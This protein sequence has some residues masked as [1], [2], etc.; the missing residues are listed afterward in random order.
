[1]FPDYDEEEIFNKGD[2][3]KVSKEYN[4]WIFGGIEGKITGK[5]DVSYLYLKSNKKTPETT[6]Q[7][8]NDDGFVQY[9]PVR[10]LEKINNSAGG[11]RRKSK[12]SKRKSRCGG[13]KGSRKN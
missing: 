11:R 6:Y 2:R 7:V 5:K 4:D 13:R 12:T 10:F 3:V 8:E 9:I 1:M